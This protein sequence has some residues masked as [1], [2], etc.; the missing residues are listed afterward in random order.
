MDSR[1]ALGLLAA[2]AAAPALAGPPPSFAGTWSI[3][4][5]PPEQAGVAADCG[6]ASLVLRQDGR[7]IQGSFH[8]AGTDCVALEAGAAVA[9]LATG[10]GATL[11]IRSSR[12]GAVLRGRA[13]V[14]GDK[15]Y[16]QVRNIV[17]RGKP[18]GDESIL[19]RG[20]LRRGG[21]PDGDGAPPALSSVARPAGSTGR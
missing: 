19:Q 8:H 3:D 14:R 9:G 4:L 13:V 1:Y 17:V 5:R 7:R 6:R 18:E 16:W 15:L 2:L 12:N 21:A 11:E 10:A 20:I